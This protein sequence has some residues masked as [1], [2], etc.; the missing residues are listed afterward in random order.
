MVSTPSAVTCNPNCRPSCTDDTS[1]AART[2]SLVAPWT[3]A[4]SIFSSVN[5]VEMRLYIE[6]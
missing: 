6:L 1:A 5:G 2:S 3:K 4:R